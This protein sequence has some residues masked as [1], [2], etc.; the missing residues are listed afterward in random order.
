VRIVVEV[1][2]DTGSAILALLFDKLATTACVA[3]PHKLSDGRRQ[4]A[5]W[6]HLLGDR[7]CNKESK[8]L[9]F[10]RQAQS[11]LVYS[12]RRA[13]LM[14]RYYRTKPER[15]AEKLLQIRTALGLS[16]NEMIK[17]LGLDDVLYQAHISG[18]ER[19]IREPSLPVLLAYARAAGVWADVL[20]DDTLDLPD[21]LPSSMKS[22]GVRRKFAT[23]SKRR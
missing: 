3:H 16:Q 5:E 10:Q 18:F 19:G 15:L 13:G 17:H 12:I 6:L 4:R 2:G 23:R 14:G 7:S 20:M 22:E 21:K 1:T 11:G 8:T 9:L